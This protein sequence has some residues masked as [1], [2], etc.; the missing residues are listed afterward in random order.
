MYECVAGKAFDVEPGRPF[1]GDAVG[2]VDALQDSR[3]LVL[4][5]A[6]MRAD[7]ERK[8]DLRR[9]REPRH[10]SACASA[11]NSAG[12]SASALVDEVR[13]IPARAAAASAR[14]ASPVSSSEFGSVLRRWENAAV[15]SRLSSG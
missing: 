7:H 12:E 3:H 14:L 1:D 10:S 2:E 5:V 4:A 9:S 11:T 15:T 6:S 8:I 13:P